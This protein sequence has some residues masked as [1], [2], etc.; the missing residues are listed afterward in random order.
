MLKELPL[1]W[2]EYHMMYWQGRSY[3]CEVCVWWDGHV[4]IMEMVH[5]GENNGYEQE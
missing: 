5:I 2:F 1:F 3:L 4:E